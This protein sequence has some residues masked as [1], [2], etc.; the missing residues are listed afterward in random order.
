[1]G[2]YSEEYVDE[3]S[4]TT[5]S[6]ATCATREPPKDDP[7]CFVTTFL[8]ERTPVVGRVGLR[9]WERTMPPDPGP[10]TELSTE[11]GDDRP[12]GEA[13]RPKAGAP[14]QL[15]VTARRRRSPEAPKS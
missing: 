10:W 12:Q 14:G 3:S 1:M 7:T 9:A 4:C 11:P 5:W 8:G 2:E 15:A 13:D 6:A